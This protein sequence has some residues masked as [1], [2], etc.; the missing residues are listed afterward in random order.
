V[1]RRI[2]ENKLLG[3]WQEHKRSFPWRET[4]D[5]Y[6]LAIT[7]LMLVRTKADQ[8][9][10]VWHQFFERFPDVS[11]LAHA[12]HEELFEILGSLGLAWRV[13]LVGEFAQRVVARY[14]AHVP[15]GKEELRGVLP[16]G[17]YAAAAVALQ[18][19]GQGTLP[20]DTAI[21][22]FVDRFFGLREKGELRR[23]AKVLE[24]VRTL[25]QCSRE[26]FFALLD[27][28]WLVCLPREPLCQQCPLQHRCCYGRN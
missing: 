4:R 17:E 26:S 10:R 14:G 3:W 19:R 13:K 15:A 5:P 25:G 6:H 27:L 16:V 22:R 12:T 1:T 11:S 7:E 28:T 24:T 20:V 9:A 21:A 18:V 23:N 8:V 2:P